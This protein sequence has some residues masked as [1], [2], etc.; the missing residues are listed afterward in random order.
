MDHKYL[1]SDFSTAG[2]FNELETVNFFVGKLRS[3]PRCPEL[4]EKLLPRR[5]RPLDREHLR[6]IVREKQTE[7]FRSVPSRRFSIR[8]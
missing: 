5:R 7:N 1:P 8:N 3:F 6:A 2:S 4:L